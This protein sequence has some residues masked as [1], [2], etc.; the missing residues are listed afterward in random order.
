MNIF[1]RSK[2]GEHLKDPAVRE[3]GLAK[4][5]QQAEINKARA[6]TELQK[7]ET[8]LKIEKLKSE[9]AV[10]ELEHE[11]SELEGYEEEPEQS[12]EASLM[13]ALLGGFMKG[14]QPVQQTEVLLPDTSKVELDDETIAAV[15]SGLPK[16]YVIAAQ[17]MTD[18]HIIQ[19]IKAQGILPHASD[20]SLIRLVTYAKSL[21]KTKKKTK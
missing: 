12:T 4:R 2:Q 7:E 15:V 21:N 10:L 9:R 1:K 16:Q 19:L 13:T 14:Q 20:S 5:R 3:L 8:K 11:L 6:E 17:T 18:E